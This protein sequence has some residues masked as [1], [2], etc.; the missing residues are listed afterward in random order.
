MPRALSIA[1]GLLMLLGAFATFIWLIVRSVK[2]S[3]DPAKLIFKWVL[4]F[5]LVAA[6]FGITKG[7]GLDSLGALAIPSICVAF[8]VAMSIIWAPSLG[9][10]MARPITSMFDGG[11]KELEPQPFYSVAIANPQPRTLHAPPHQIPN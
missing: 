5:G 6:L 3:D 8:G 1:A 7:I 10:A 9:A 2:R 4:T 11:D